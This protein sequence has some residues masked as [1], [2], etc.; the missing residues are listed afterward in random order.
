M[1][2]RTSAIR[3]ADDKHGPAGARR[4]RYVPTYMLRGLQALY[5]ELDRVA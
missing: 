4:F 5:L 1:L 3:I 2:E